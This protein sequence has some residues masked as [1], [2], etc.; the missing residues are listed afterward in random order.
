MMAAK[1]FTGLLDAFDRV[2]V[3][4]PKLLFVFFFFSV[5]AELHLVHIEK[6]L[7][8]RLLQPY[9]F[10]ILLTARI[11]THCLLQSLT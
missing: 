3:V 11:L 6:M 2:K 7:I 4:T 1:T 5:Y 8:C 10:F 9:P